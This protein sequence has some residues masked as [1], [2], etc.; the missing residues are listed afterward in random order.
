MITHLINGRDVKEII[1]AYLRDKSF[2]SVGELLIH[3]S[4]PIRDPAKPPPTMED[5]YF[6]YLML[7]GQIK[8]L[9]QEGKVIHRDI[10][11]QIFVKLNENTN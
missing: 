2:V 5:N 11:N 4:V 10:D 6:F 3:C 9:S 8:D 7:C 1:L